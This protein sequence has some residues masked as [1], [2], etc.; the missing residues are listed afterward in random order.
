MQL[1]PAAVL[2]TPNTT[3]EEEADGQREVTYTDMQVRG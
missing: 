2:P 1:F 3:V